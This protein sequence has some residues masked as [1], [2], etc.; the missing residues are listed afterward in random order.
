MLI[1]LIKA[2]R[3]CRGYD[4]S[5]AVTEEELKAMVDCARLSATGGNFQPLKYYVTND[6]EETAV[7]NGLVKLGAM[8][9]ELHLPFAG[10][11]AP[12]YILICHDRNISQETAFSMVD[13]GAAAQSIALAATEMGLNVCMAGAF[14]PEKVSEALGLAPNL[15]VK[16][17]LPV[18]KSAETF[19]LVELPEDGST[20]YYRDENGVHCVPKRSLDEV[21]ITK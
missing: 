7:L 14:S 5:R 10:Q 20:K 18:G 2:N 11:E 8:L 15:Q 12:A 21:L 17:I 16:L 1:D 9:P 19:R 13:V 4:R 6:P 3:S